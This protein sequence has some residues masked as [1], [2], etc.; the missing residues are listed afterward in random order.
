MGRRG[1]AK[2]G[3]E[4][5]GRSGNSASGGDG[6][7]AGLKHWH[8]RLGVCFGFSAWSSVLW[9]ARKSVACQGGFA[10]EYSRFQRSFAYYGRAAAAIVARGSPAGPDACLKT[11]DAVYQSAPPDAVC[12]IDASVQVAWL[13]LSEMTRTLPSIIERFIR[14]GW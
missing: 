5:R 10:T 4:E 9:L 12:R 8:F 1:A 13:M 14:P 11:A 2:K 3:E 6:R 7:V